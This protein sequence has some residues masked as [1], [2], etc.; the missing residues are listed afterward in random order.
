MSLGNDER[1]PRAR[2]ASNVDSEQQHD[3]VSVP[4]RDLWLAQVVRTPA[5]SDG[6][7]VLCLWLSTTMDNNGRVRAS[8]RDLARE[9]GVAERRIRERLKE[10]DD[11]SGAGWLT[12]LRPGKGRAPTL[13]RAAIGSTR[14]RERRPNRL[15]TLTRSG[16][17]AAHYGE[18]HHGSGRACAP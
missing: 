1:P 6:A 14:E 7:R 17:D 3:G 2:G 9:L 11:E 16:P 8:R 18:H 13:W 10:L 4:R 15:D 5:I 12:V